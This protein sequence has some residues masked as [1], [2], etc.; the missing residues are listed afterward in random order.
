MPPE[1]KDELIKVF[2]G[3]E[4]EPRSLVDIEHSLIPVCAGKFFQSFRLYVVYEGKDKDKIV[5][6]LH[7]Q[8]H[9][10]DSVSP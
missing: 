6:D 3:E 10:W 2:V 8:V 4:P 9:N 7:E 1:D 5:S